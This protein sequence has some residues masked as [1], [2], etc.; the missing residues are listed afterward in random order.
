MKNH[1]SKVQVLAI[2]TFAF[3]VFCTNIAAA[4]EPEEFNLDTVLVT[5][6]RTPMTEKKI[7]QAVQVITAKDIENLG[8]ANVTDALQLAANVNLSK[9]GMTGNQV[10]IR[11]MDTAHTLILIDG[12]RMAAEDANST[13]NV[14]ELNRVNVSDIERI[15]IVRGN[16]SALY[17]SDAL[18][19]VINIITKRP[20]VAKTTLG[21]NTGTEE[22]STYLHYDTGKQGKWSISTSARITD[23]RSQQSDS[24]DSTNMNGPKRYI[25]FKAD[26]DLGKGKGKGLTF[27]MSHLKEQLREYYDDDLT[28]SKVVINQ[29]E[30]FDNN[31]SAYGLTY[32]GK[33]SKNNYQ[34]RTYYNVLKKESR[35]T[36]NSAWSDF[37]H[38]QYET[39]V[40]EGKNSSKLNE[41]HLLTY[42]GEYR[43]NFVRGTRM[44][45]GGD[46]TYEDYYLGLEK[47]GSEK[48]LE[49]YSAYVQDEWQINEKMFIIPALRYDYHTSFGSNLSPKLG[50]TY[51][52]SDNTRLK[53]NYGKSYRVPTISLLYYEMTRSMGKRIVQVLG[54]PDLQ[55]ETSI[56]FDFGIEAEKDNN[57]GKLTY[58]NNSVSNLITSETVSKT[59]TKTIARYINVNKAQINGVEVE[60]GRH[61][62]KHL[63]VKTTYNWLDAIDKETNERLNNRAKK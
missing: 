21:I 51:N 40:I 1:I 56:S 25:D 2:S 42:G 17:G 46:N 45:T 49:N 11:G 18:G 12:K 32:Y 54:N 23:V 10:S 8:A 19:G 59:S 47:T 53:A 55:P 29:K 61:L 7:P 57:W 14:Y 4:S 24:D 31:R 6:T 22:K 43:N 13:A 48:Y 16:G 5:A 33:D 9:A 20:G 36:N 28:S 52:L 27:D 62:N 41:K 58:F 63:S 26:Y 44:G 30:W 39:F 60:L 35:K 3:S 50:T 34:L 15:E 37:D 38:M